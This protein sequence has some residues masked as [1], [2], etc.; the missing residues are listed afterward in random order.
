MRVMK[1]DC[2]SGG[3]WTGA[4]IGNLGIRCGWG[5]LAL[6][7]TLA[8]VWSSTASAVPIVHPVVG[9]FVDIEVR[10]GG[11]TIGAAPGVA[12]TGDTVT[13]DTAA[14]TVDGL[15][16]ELAPTTISL[17]QPFGGYD[18]ITVESAVLESD[19]FFSTL[20][21]FGDAFLFTAVAGPFTVTGSWGATDSAGINPVTSGNAISFPVLSLIAI[22]NLNPLL[23]LNSVT[24][25]SIDGAPF[26]HPGEHLTIVGTYVVLTP[27]PGTA[28]L[29]GLGLAVLAARRRR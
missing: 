20:G 29:L 12:L 1:V 17:T 10:L 22:A 24:I 27:E 28:L 7:A 4:R 25:N 18:E 8:C 21:S 9:G 19:A 23:E 3:L 15:R 11:V 14:L 26:G 16:L 2:R 13:V 6:A 5:R